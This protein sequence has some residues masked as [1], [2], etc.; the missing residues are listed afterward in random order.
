[1]RRG[2]AD[3]VAFAL[4]GA[5]VLG[6]PLIGR[7]QE[8]GHA[9]EALPYFQRA[10]YADTAG[11]PASALQYL[12]SAARIA[13]AQEDDATLAQALLNTGLVR[14]RHGDH[15]AALR[16][17]YKA[18]VVFER[19]GHQRGLAE[20]YNNI[21]S[22]FHYQ[23]NFDKAEE[24]YAL[25]LRI[26]ERL[27]SERGIGKVLNNFGALA[28]DR[29]DLQKAIAY[30]R[31]SLD[32]WTAVR[33]SIWQAVS[34]AN[35]GSCFDALGQHDS[36]RVCYAKSLRALRGE[37][38]RYQYGTVC[39]RMG[40][41]HLG[42]GHAGKAV[43]WCMQGLDIA[44]A[45]NNLPMENR[46]CDCLYQAFAAKGDARSELRFYRRFVVT[47]DSLFNDHRIEEMTRSEMLHEFEKHQ[48]EDSLLQAQERAL[49]QSEHEE[50]LRIEAGKR[51]LLLYSGG[52]LLVLIGG[53]WSR[54]RYIRRSRSLLQAERDRGDDLLNNILPKVV[55]RELFEKGRVE[56]RE[57]PAATVLFT[58]FEHFTTV[59]EQLSASELVELV[60]TC[61][62]AFDA[63][64]IK[65]GVEKIK[66]VGD[67][68][69]ACGGVPDPAFGSPVDVIIAALE[70]Q[71]YIVALH[72]QRTALGLPAFRMRVGVHTG[73][74]VGGIVGS[75]KFAYDI[76]GDAVNIAARMENAGAVGRVNVSQATY[77]LVKADPRLCFEPR[78]MVEAKGKGAMPM[79]WVGA[80]A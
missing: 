48:F 1:M 65:H 17:F 76:W 64:L 52:A 47:K 41:S 39:I 63:I 50:S 80:N 66:T 38:E 32:V 40:M 11:D 16:E 71:R 8:H 21:G 67:A 23:R 54:L 25:G 53:L 24:H 6:L 75:H 73:P 30:H 37:D 33:D 9:I 51:D 34:L 62:K 20:V 4:I 79:Y 69:L 29:G 55:A 77:D 19:M 42:S 36:A 56:A 7:S 43:E 5:A 74:V 35:I 61:F 60:D 72:D 2:R 3:R 78:G 22:I 70:M 10:E 18:Q 46:A 57:F 26:E 58:D 15:S 59:A 31:R 14:L 12:D 45:R 49:V 27:G 44:L 28:E 68:Y 13:T